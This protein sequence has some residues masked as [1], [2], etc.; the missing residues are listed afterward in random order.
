MS[1][2]AARDWCALSVHVWTKE[3]KLATYPLSEDGI[4]RVIVP[5]GDVAMT[6]RICA[7]CSHW[8]KR[9]GMCACEKCGCINRQIQE[10]ELG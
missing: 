9:T 2:M 1:R 7:T 10:E 4:W 6:F 5:F 3:E 8:E